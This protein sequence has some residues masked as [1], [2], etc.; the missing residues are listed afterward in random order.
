MGTGKSTVGHIIA[1]TLCFHFVDTD[2]L[3]EKRTGRKIADIFQKE[4]EPVF[5]QIESD[6]VRDLEIVRHNVIATGGGLILTPG[7]LESLRR[8]ALIICLWASPEVIWSRVRHQNHRP[9]LNEADPQ[10]K[11]RTLL[12]QREQFYRQA[13]ILLNSEF[14]SAKQV[15]N[16]AV[17]QFRLA[18]SGNY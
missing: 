6:M 4:G 13:D 2:E 15:A 5:R 14:R 7:N 11:I 3:I 9:L 12:A 17:H 10:A 8:H 18:S 16:H 1:S